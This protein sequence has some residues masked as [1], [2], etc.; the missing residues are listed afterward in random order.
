M[1][2]VINNL[3]VLLFFADRPAVS[4]KGILKVYKIEDI[5]SHDYH[6]NNKDD[7]LFLPK[8]WAIVVIKIMQEFLIQ[9]KRN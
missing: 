5:L 1:G 7:S 8:I 3:C 6:D 9:Y 4:K 2:Y